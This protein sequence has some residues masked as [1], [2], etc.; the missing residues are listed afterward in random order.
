MTDAMHASVSLHARTVHIRPMEP[1]DAEAAA[2]LCAELG[3][4]RNTSDVCAWIAT[5]GSNKE[6]QAAFVAC[7]DNE[8]IGWV[9]VS[10]ERRLQSPPFAL[11]GGL[12]VKDG[13]RGQGIGRLLCKQAEEWAWQHG[14]DKIRVTSRSTRLDAHRF[15]LQSGFQETKLSR[16]FEKCHEAK[17]TKA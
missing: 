2:H 11:I 4:Q 7:K 5:I 1:R 3:Y 17:M 10:M 16:V 8:V 14:A 9:E 15:Y 12:I 6:G 13:A